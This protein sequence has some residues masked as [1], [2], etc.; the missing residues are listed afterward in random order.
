MAGGSQTGGRRS[1]QSAIPGLH[2]NGAPIGAQQFTSPQEVQEVGAVQ[3]AWEVPGGRRHR[4]RSPQVKRAAEVLEKAGEGKARARPT[5]KFGTRVVNMEG[6]EAAPVSFFI[7]NTNPKSVKESIE[8]V[9]I[10]CANETSVNKLKVE[11]IEVISVT[12]VDNPRTRCWKLTVPN[13]WRETFREDSF[14]PMGWSHCPWSNRSLGNSK[15]STK[16]QRTNSSSGAGEQTPQPA[17]LGPVSQAPAQAPGE[18]QA[19][20]P[21]APLAVDSPV[22]GQ[23]GALQTSM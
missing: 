1:G 9:I 18:G 3:G 10:Q 16:K 23:Q 15:D 19:A 2:V 4:T 13:K 14:W 17:P 21:Q 5:A 22:S 11:E 7:G 8:K 12:K 20:L 6:A